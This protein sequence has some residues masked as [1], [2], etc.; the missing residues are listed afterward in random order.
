[1]KLKLGATV[2][3][4]LG[5]LGLVGCGGGGPDPVASTATF[6]L[7]A[8][9][10]AALTSSKSY[11]ASAADGSDT[12]TLMLAASPTADEVFEGSNSKVTSVSLTL[13]KNGATASVTS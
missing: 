4:F 11:S 2:G 7:D 9:Q 13:K 1:M 6:P 8:A 12:W 10:T 5:A 3:I